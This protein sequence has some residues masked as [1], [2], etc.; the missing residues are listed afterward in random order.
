M[1][2]PTTAITVTGGS[3]PAQIW[4]RFMAEAMAPLPV[5]DF[6]TPPPATTVAPTA[7]AAPVAVAPPPTPPAAAPPITAPVG[8]QPRPTIPAPP[9]VVAVPYVVGMGSA[10]A[11]AA[12]Q[13]AGLEARLFG[14]RSAG[15]VVSQ[16][17]A[18]G[19]QVPPGSAVTLVVRA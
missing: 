14:P 2:P 1:V 8:T 18:G 6:A 16:W 10:E 13:A 3:W 15:R 17:P 9:T 12:M 5:V 11:V 7:V 4:Q 19:T